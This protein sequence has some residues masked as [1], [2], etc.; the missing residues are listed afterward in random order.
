MSQTSSP[1]LDGV[2]SSTSEAPSRAPRTAASSVGT[3]RISTP[4]GPRCSRIITRAVKY[5][6]DGITRTPSGGTS[7]KTTDEIAAMPDGNT[8]DRPPS[9]SPSARSSAVQVGFP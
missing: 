4:R 5:P 1:G 7:E 2:S 6:S 3:S 9:S 8:S